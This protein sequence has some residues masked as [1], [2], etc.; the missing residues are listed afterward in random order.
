MKFLFY[1]TVSLALIPLL[2]VLP[3]A[4]FTFILVEGEGTIPGMRQEYI[5]HSLMIIYPIAAV[6]CGYFAIK[7]FRRM[8]GLRHYVIGVVPLFL[9][10]ML[11][12]IF[13]NG[14]IQIL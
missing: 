10:I 14:G 3:L 9:F 7:G 4:P 8:P 11:V 1:F 5:F 6:L 13:I 2:L 12:A